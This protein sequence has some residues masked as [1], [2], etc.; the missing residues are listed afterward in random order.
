MN[1]A[2][3]P[4]ASALSTS[5]PCLMPPSK[6]TSSRSP[7]AS[8]ISGS[9]SMVPL[10][11]CRAWPPWLETIS[12]SAPCSAHRTASSAVCTP[13]TISGMEVMERSHS[14]SAQLRELSK[15][16]AKFSRVGRL[17]SSMPSEVLQ[18]PF[19]LQNVG[20]AVLPFPGVGAQVVHG[21]HQ[22]GVPRVLGPAHQDLRQLPVGKEIQLEPQ[23]TGG[24]GG[25][26]FYAV[27]GGGAQAEDGAPGAGGPGRRQLAQRVGP[28]VGAGGGQHYGEADLLS[29]HL[30]GEVAP[31]HVHQDPGPELHA[32]EGRHV[33]GVGSPVGS[34]DFPEQPVEH[35]LG[36]G[37]L[38]P[39]L[40]V[41]DAQQ[42][43]LRGQFIRTSGT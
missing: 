20:V 13:L 41:G 21:Q 31:A 5:V 36:H 19:R 35:G 2:F 30:G 38:G 12:A 14:R 17:G 27:A 26:L 16:S 42:R 23:R 18:G 37:L 9:I 33:V 15:L 43:R 10:L 22:P 28:L 7:T 29:Q 1:T 34:A 6:Y 39:A 40:V 4:R 25:D 32:V 3:A 11:P 8:A 24:G